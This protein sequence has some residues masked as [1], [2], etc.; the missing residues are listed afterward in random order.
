METI[1][2][3]ELRQNASRY[4]DRVAQGETIEVTDRGRP[5]ARLVPTQGSVRDRLAAAGRLRRRKGS[6]SELGQPLPPRTGKPLPSEILARM[7]E[8]ER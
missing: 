8:T 6:W 5:V 2:V 7:R 3:R 1:G 4:L